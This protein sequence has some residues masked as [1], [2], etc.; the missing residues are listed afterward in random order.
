MLCMIY[1]YTHTRLYI[2]HIISYILNLMLHATVD[3]IHRALLNV[4]SC[5][6]VVCGAISEC[7]ILFD[8]MMRC[9]VVLVGVD[10]GF[11]VGF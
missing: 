8:T 9:A 1:G 6:L 4:V 10:V 7:N 2:A 11:L 5:L 3:M